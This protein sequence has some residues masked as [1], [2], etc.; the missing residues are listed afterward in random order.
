MTE[1]LTRQQ[2]AEKTKLGVRTID[3][4]VATNGIP[5]VKIRRSVRFCPTQLEEW[6]KNLNTN[7]KS[8]N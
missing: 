2:V 6:V 5:F 1:L 4:L 7:N 3:N 8:R